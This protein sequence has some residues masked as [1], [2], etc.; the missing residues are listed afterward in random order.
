MSARQAT[1]VQM[2]ERIRPATRKGVRDG[3][4]ISRANEGGVIR[5][6]GNG[7]DHAAVRP[8]AGPAL[9]PAAGRGEQRPDRWQIGWVS[10]A[11]WPGGPP[12][13][14]DKCDRDAAGAAG[15]AW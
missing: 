2:A 10:H 6:D 3:T 14:L 8:D 4:S 5:A 1:A 11:G 15:G 13:C 7:P 9:R 12:G